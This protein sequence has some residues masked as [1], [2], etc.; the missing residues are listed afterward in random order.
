VSLFF[1]DNTQDKRDMF[2]ALDEYE[3]HG[4]LPRL[5][6]EFD[7][8]LDN[9]RVNREDFKRTVSKLAAAGNA[10]RAKKLVQVLNDHDPQPWIRIPLLVVIWPFVL[11]YRILKLGIP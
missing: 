10:Q 2:N 7:V 1:I 3:R 4:D 9:V 8:A 6:S 11:V 5:L